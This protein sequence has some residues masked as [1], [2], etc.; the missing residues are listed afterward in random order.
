MPGLTRREVIEFIGGQRE[1]FLQLAFIRLQSYY[2][3]HPEAIHSRI[4]SSQ[5]SF[6]TRLFARSRLVQPRSCVL[7]VANNLS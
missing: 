4:I 2:L 7:T 1:K 5:A 6:R 3:P